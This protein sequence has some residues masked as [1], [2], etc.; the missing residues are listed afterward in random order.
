M[1]VS[2]AIVGDL[3]GAFHANAVV[4]LCMQDLFPIAGRMPGVPVLV[5]LPVKNLK[6]TTI[7]RRPMGEL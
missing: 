3:R 5:L 1:F 7:E 4:E 6:K 2:V